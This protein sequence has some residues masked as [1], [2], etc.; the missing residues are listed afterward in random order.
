ME[1]RT[2]EWSIVV[3]NGVSVVEHY[4]HVDPGY[5]NYGTRY[6]S[7]VRVNR[8]HTIMSRKELMPGH[9][10]LSPSDLLSVEDD[11]T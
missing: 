11:G 2:K 4:F 6:C 9:G 7:T 10:I 1:K 8:L 5:K 3:F